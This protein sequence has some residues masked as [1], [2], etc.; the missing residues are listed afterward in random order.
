METIQERVRA[1]DRLPPLLRF[2]LTIRPGPQG[3]PQK[4][5]QAVEPVNL[6]GGIAGLTLEI[7]A[8]PVVG[9][10]VVDGAAA[11]H[12]PA[13]LNY[14]HPAAA[15]LSADGGQGA[16]CHGSGLGE[17]M[18]GGAAQPRHKVGHLGGQGAALQRPQ[19]GGGRGRRQGGHD[20]V[21]GGVD[22]GR[23]LAAGGD[24]SAELRDLL[25]VRGEMVAIDD[26]HG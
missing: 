7:H 21:A 8:A 5:G 20:R 2:F 13:L 12:G 18:Q 19:Q 14:H 1:C 23:P 6:R 26:G 3:P 11:G 10:D 4:L 24:E 25:A 17:G 22:Q 9:V 16:Q 15:G